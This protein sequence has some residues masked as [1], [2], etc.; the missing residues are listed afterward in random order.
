VGPGR[1]PIQ[2]PDIQ[3]LALLEEQLFHSMADAPEISDS[4][5]M[6]HLLESLGM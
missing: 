4:T 2:F 6:S 5:I 1:P 3:I